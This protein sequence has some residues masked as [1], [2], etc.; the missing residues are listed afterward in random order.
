VSDVRIDWLTGELSGV[1][2]EAKFKRL[3]DMCGAYRD[4]AAFNRMSADQIIYSV[5]FWRPVEEGTPGGLFWG[6]TR[7]LPG[8]VGD[9]YFM[10]AGHFH[11]ERDRAEYY[12]V[13][14]G[15]GGLL[16]MDEA[17]NTRWERMSAGTAHY[18]PGHVAHR[19]ANT[20]DTPLVFVACWPSDA[21]HDYG[22][23]LEHGFSARLRNVDGSAR[24]VSEGCP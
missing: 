13:V 17:R 7:I 19:V 20:G 24:L 12:A 9:E 21:G 2:V 14:L 23:I 4:T 15:E 11:A 3:R 1:P 5:Q 16:L 10:T 8:T 18:I 6:Q 22:T